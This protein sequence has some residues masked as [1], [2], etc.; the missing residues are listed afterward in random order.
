VNVM[1]GMFIAI[2]GPTGV[3]KTTLAAHL[4][5]AL[6]ACTMLDPFDAN[7]FFREWVTAAH[8]R[9]ELVL[10]AELMFVAL[11]VAQLRE[12]ASQLT[13]GCCVVSARMPG[14]VW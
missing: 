3:G 12:I 7:P 2:E 4:A 9:A 5:P 14:V 11:R 10:R 8:P 6:N 1:S 13:A